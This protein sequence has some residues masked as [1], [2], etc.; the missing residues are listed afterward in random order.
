MIDTVSYK[1]KKRY[2]YKF[3]RQIQPI[4]DEVNLHFDHSELGCLAVGNSHICMV[5]VGLDSNVFE[6]YPPYPQLDEEIPLSVDSLR[7]AMKPFEFDEVLNVTVSQEKQGKT[8]VIIKSGNK[9]TWFKTISKTEQPSYPTKLKM[10]NELELENS[11]LRVLAKMTEENVQFNTL[12]DYK[13]E[14]T[15]KEESQ[16]EE[17]TSKVYMRLLL[18][19]EVKQLKS[20]AKSIYASDRLEKISKA[21]PKDRTLTIEIGD[22]Y[23][24]KIL[25]EREEGAVSGH[26]LVAPRITESG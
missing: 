5:S 26:Y 12:T 7:E 14:V 6:E 15:N 25:F 16:E 3:V 8:K 20:N 24:A 17:E 11:D 10:E 19:D 1:V 9:E 2:L 18:S 22:D 23:P 4:R 13:M 21:I